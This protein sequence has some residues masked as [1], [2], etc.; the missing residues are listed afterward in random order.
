M[1]ETLLTAA[2]VRER[3]REA[4]NKAAGQYPW[5]RLNGLSQPF[6]NQIINGKRPISDAVASKISLRR[7]TSWADT[8]DDIDEARDAA[9]RGLK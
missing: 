6:I 5:S 2:Q 1:A 4:C 3:L 8:S 7:V 9:G